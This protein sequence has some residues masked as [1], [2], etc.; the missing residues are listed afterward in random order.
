MRRFS[1]WMRA[2]PMVGDSVIALVV[3]LMDLAIL[4]AATVADQPNVQPWYIG[5]PVIVAAV[6]PL[7]I[8]RKH[9]LIFAYAVLVLGVPHA[10]LE[11]GLTALITG[12]I[13]VYTLVAYVGRRQA[14]LYLAAQLLVSTVQIGIQLPSSEWLVAGGFTAGMLAFSWVL[15]EFIGARRAYHA[16]LEARLHLLETER[17]QATRIAVADERTRIARELHDVVA[18]AVSVIVVQAEGASYAICSDPDAARHAVRTIADTG[19]GA[20]NEL[21]TL[22]DVLRNSD[23]EASPLAPQP[24]LDAL[25]ALVERMRASGLRVTLQVPGDL[26]GLPAGV[27]LGVYRIVQES[28]TNTLKHAGPGARAQVRVERTPAGVEVRVDDDGAGRFPAAG[29]AAVTGGN[30]VIGMRERAVVFGGS[31]EAG[32]DPSGGWRV[33]AALPLND[34]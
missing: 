16:E 19:R 22:L 14:A 27:A 30:G 10:A 8:R 6:A 23:T 2:H 17:D 15:G 31:L 4:I 12:S 25:S 29:L 1:L 21:R 24:D 13:A 5:V 20:L 3:G 9:P 18:H 11:L 32:P 34:S 7:V 28:L 26:T 33:H